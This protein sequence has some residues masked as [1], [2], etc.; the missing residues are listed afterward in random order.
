MSY[1]FFSGRLC[2]TCVADHGVTLD[3]QDCTADSCVAGL[4]LFILLCELLRMLR[5]F[6]RVCRAWVMVM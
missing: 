2:G 3:L 1:T 4:V 6:M 5:Y